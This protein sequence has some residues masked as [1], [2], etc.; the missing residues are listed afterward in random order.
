MYGLYKSSTTVAYLLGKVQLRQQK[1][2]RNAVAAEY[3]Q[4]TLDS[5]SNLQ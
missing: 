2:L 5:Y 3:P 1:L 4:C